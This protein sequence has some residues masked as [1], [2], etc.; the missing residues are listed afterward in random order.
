ML[1][2]R[3][4]SARDQFPLVTRISISATDHAQTT[5][6]TQEPTRR[7]AGGPPTAERG[8]A[9]EVRNQADDQE[10]QDEQADPV[11]ASDECF[12]ACRAARPDRTLLMARVNRLRE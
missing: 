1:D 8:G 5:R 10:R 9:R 3:V 11:S 7:A 2:E 12:Q 6:T 4:R